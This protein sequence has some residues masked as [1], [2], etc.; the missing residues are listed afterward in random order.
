MMVSSIHKYFEKKHCLYKYC[1]QQDGGIGA[2]Q[3]MKKKEIEPIFTGKVGRWQKGKNCF[4]C[5]STVY[6]LGVAKHFGTKY[7][8]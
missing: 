8:V 3:R 1:I 5:A 4:K 7:Y 6:D 2:C